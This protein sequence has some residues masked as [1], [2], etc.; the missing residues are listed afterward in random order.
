M[1]FYIAT[2]V[3]RA[4]G[5]KLPVLH[6]D[7]DVVVYTDAEV[8]HYPENS[9]YKIYYSPHTHSITNDKSSVAQHGQ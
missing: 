8:S 3:R 1:N 2:A 4:I 9:L 5:K 7:A 6:I